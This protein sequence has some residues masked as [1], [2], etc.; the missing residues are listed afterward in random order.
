MRKYCHLY[1]AKKP[2]KAEKPTRNMIRHAEPAQE[3]SAHT[4][5]N[6]NTRVARAL[7]LHVLCDDGF[8]GFTTHKVM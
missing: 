5:N 6:I 2:K 3:G 1:S 8:I 4:P 7:F